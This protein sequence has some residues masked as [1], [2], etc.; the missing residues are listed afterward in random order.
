[1]T[2]LANEIEAL[3]CMAPAKRKAEV[4]KIGA[5]KLRTHWALWAHPGQLAP[6]GDWRTWLLLA[7]RGYGKSRAGAE[8][9]RGL[10]EGDGAARIALVGATLNEA[11]SI[12]VEGDSGLLTIAPHDNRPKWEPSR[13]RLTWRNGAQATLFSG[14]NPDGLRGPQ[15][16][17][18]WC[19]ELAKWAYGQ[20]TWDN[21][22]MGLRL[23]DKPMALVTT[24]PRPIALIRAL[25]TEQQ[26]A[27]TR[28]AMVDNPFLPEAFITAMERAY[29]GTRLGRQELDGEMIADL[30]G[31][32]WTRD[33]I[34][35]CRVRA[36]PMFKRVVVAV[37]PPAGVGDGADACGIIAC[38]LGE[39]G[40]GYVIEDASL[41]GATP[42]GWARAVAACVARHGADRLIAESNQGGAMVASVLRGAGLSLP[43][44]LIHASRGK[45]ARAEPVAALYEA[46]RVA[47]IGAFPMLEDEL[48]GLMAGGA[49]EGSGRS[50]DRADALV[51]A[52]TELMLGVAR[53]VRGRSL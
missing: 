29:A 34:E 21:L 47:H 26:V 45:V 40:C 31:A 25:M 15:H 10:A 27:V 28:G 30:P 6:S 7:G 32:L 5:E 52:L 24:T 49:Y 1:M 18:A 13:N 14:E 3:A 23:G 50:P 33:Q 36:A 17:Y 22:Q 9:V 2:L 48:C 35:A 16:H 20:A 39:D 42:E 44:K 19:D 38:G 4:A 43:V 37:D 12:M 46:G 53:V 51:Y 11:R 8:W 41:Q